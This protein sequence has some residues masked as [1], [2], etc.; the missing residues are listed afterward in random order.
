IELQSFA[1]ELTTQH[2]DYL[3]AFFYTCVNA[4]VEFVVMEVA[5]QALSL[6][7]TAGLE[8]DGIIFTNFAQA[9]GEFYDSVEEY[10]AA[11]R[12]IFEQKKSDAQLV[13]NADDQKGAE[14]L[15]MFGGCGFG[16]HADIC[17]K[18]IQSSVSGI[19]AT[20]ADDQDKFSIQCPALI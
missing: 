8:F 15:K 11:K 1:T 14:L 10:F 4:G 16:L 19:E 2:P 3:H 17:A 9:H 13:I 12:A 18:D 6:H 20:I 5:A 7:R